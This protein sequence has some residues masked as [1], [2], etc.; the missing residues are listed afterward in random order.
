MAQERK[1]SPPLA[2]AAIAASVIKWM[3]NAAME[4]MMPSLKRQL[5]A[6]G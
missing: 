5:P 2:P 1:H 6:T 3:A 4:Q